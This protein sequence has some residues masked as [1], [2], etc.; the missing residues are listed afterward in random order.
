MIETMAEV[1]EV[2]G[3]VAFGGVAPGTG[4][5]GGCE[6]GEGLFVG[7][8]RVEKMADVAVEI[9]DGCVER[10]V[11]LEENGGASFLEGTGSEDPSLEIGVVGGG[12]PDFVLVVVDV[13]GD[14]VVVG[15]DDATI[16]GVVGVFVGG[17][18][19]FDMRETIERI[20][21]VG[22]CAV[23]KEV[24]IGVMGEVVKRE[25]IVMRV[26]GVGVVFFVSEVIMGIVGVVMGDVVLGF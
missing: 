10:V 22:V 21:G 24:A 2:G 19:C 14:G 1:D 6:G 12:A 11:K 15:G 20:V 3:V 5:C 26:V 18:G 13:E 9:V 23:R 4:E 16:E 8:V 7:F 25:A 17:G